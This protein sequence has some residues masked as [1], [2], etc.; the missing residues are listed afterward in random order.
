MPSKPDRRSKKT[1]AKSKKA[2]AVAGSPDG[3]KTWGPALQFFAGKH[4]AWTEKRAKDD[5]M[6]ALELEVIDLLAQANLLDSSQ[7]E[8]ERDFYELCS[9]WNPN[10]I[11]VATSMP[12]IY[13]PLG[14][15]I[16]YPKLDEEQIKS[17]KWDKAVNATPEGMEELFG[18]LETKAEGIRQQIR[19]FAGLLATR[20][21]F[22]DERDKLRAQWAD[23][24]DD[25]RPPLPL[26]RLSA[27]ERKHYR[28]ECG[29]LLADIEALLTKWSLVEMTTWDLPSPQG[30]LEGMTASTVE[31]LLG[32]DPSVS[33][34]P[35]Y[36]QIP[37]SQNVRRDLQNA[38]REEARKLDQPEDFPPKGLVPRGY[39]ESTFSA[40]LPMFVAELACRTR[41][42]APRGLSK[43]FEEIFQKRSGLGE[44]RVHQLRAVYISALERAHPTS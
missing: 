31:H 14:R 26:G 41:Y 21:D 42:G 36:Y 23:V 28:Q 22:L 10:C 11:G 44:D 29:N 32:R 38:Q 37:S 6:Y 17:L 35:P 13:P 19:A 5:V 7:K 3:F 2:R 34:H 16:S 4:S 27:E 33:Y 39:D 40:A 24:S 8:A 43:R 20:S 25:V 12:I 30:P 1:A 15:P 18:E 9:G